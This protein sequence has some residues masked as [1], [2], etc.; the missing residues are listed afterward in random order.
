[1]G[2]VAVRRLKKPPMAITNRVLVELLEEEKTILYR[3]EISS[4]A[5]VASS[6]SLRRYTNNYIHTKLL[7]STP[8]QN[9]SRK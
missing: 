4:L 2:N 6:E 7:N 8:P 9:E 1:M 5:T 3:C